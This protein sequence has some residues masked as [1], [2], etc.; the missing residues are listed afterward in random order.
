[1][2]EKF[3]HKI[4]QVT[5]KPIALIIESE[6]FVGDF[7][8]KALALYGCD[9]E[10]VDDLAKIDQH[11]SYNYLFC[12]TDNLARLK[13][14]LDHNFSQTKILIA[15]PFFPQQSVSYK[16]FIEETQA[17]N[18]D[19]RIIYYSYIYGP[20]M[21]SGLYRILDQLIKKGQVAPIFVSDFIYGVLK[22][23]FTGGTKGKIFSL[24]SE[25]KD[26]GWRPKVNLEDGLEQTKEWFLQ[27]ASPS[28]NFKNLESKNGINRFKVDAKN[29]KA[30]AKVSLN[31]LDKIN[32]DLD[33]NFLPETKKTEKQRQTNW[34]S[35][36]FTRHALSLT[37]CFF[38][39]VL[40]YPLTSVLFHGLVGARSLKQAQI[41]ALEGNLNTAHRKALTAK[42]NFY[43][44][45]QQLLSLDSFLQFFSQTRTDQVNDLF[46][47]G[48][49]T[50]DGLTSFTQAGQATRQ[51]VKAIFQKETI[52]IEGL[53]IS[54]KLDLE[55]SFNQL[56]L[57]ESQFDQ[58]QEV[59]QLKEVRDLILRS[60]KGLDLLPSLL[61]LKDRKSYLVLFQNNSEI[62]PTG[63][64]IGSYGILTFD[65]GQFID[66][67]IKDVYSA[68]GQL[69][70]HVEP[71]GDLKKYLGEASW[72]LRDSN[73]DPDFPTSAARAAWFLEKEIGR[74]TDGVIAIDLFL[75]QKV[76]A[77]IGEIQIPDYQEKIN[78]DN[79]FE[80]AE[81]YSEIN[82]FPGSTQKQDFLGNVARVLFEKIK[83]ADQKTWLSLAQNIYP[84]LMAKDLLIW[85]PD[86][87][88][89]F[90]VQQLGWDGGL[91]SVECL[92]DEK[93]CFPDFLMLVEANVGVNKANYFLK[94]SLNHQI[95][96]EEDGMVEETLVANYQNSSQSEAFPAG[97]YKTY[98]RL[99]TPLDSKLVKI[100]IKNLATGQ[101]E[102]V[103][104]VEQQQTY[105]KQIFGFLLEVPIQESRSVEIVYQLA[106]KLD[107]K[108]DFYHFYLQKQPGIED[109]TFSLW[110]KPSLGINITA[111]YQAGQTS[112]GLVF[113][114]N[115]NQDLPFEIKLAR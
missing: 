29:N 47:L 87:Q 65:N 21:E 38:F 55:K 41:L 99:Y 78:A 101:V 10:I 9:V 25:S 95:K 22:A 54:I 92:G 12:F 57:A 102:E 98:L 67:E 56:S 90:L 24:L 40:S 35:N 115:F 23:T 81:Y 85:L 13:K 110:F 2:D 108:D 66:F 11:K 52:D 93:N 106:R 53:I 46:Y 94:R 77:A 18:L 50:A 60:K 75:A 112:Q 105:D 86:E 103:E 48:Q 17:K 30:A 97:R 31:A 83:E 33:K 20:G 111:N 96:V 44:G 114:P 62:R 49:T 113:S 15:S 34:F 64:F 84:S 61:A 104:E 76:L 16:S 28:L 27:E 68:D 91:K 5:E 100:E 26:L 69:K 58:G 82:F 39:L 74:V 80:R 88:A 45:R 6:K 43:Q 1:M 14:F 79:F 73:W 72:Y 51:L 63:G 19:L 71:P 32:K 109:E 3:F 4:N 70:G 37:L 42:N 59:Q 107:Q 8:K 7:L 36:F 89:T